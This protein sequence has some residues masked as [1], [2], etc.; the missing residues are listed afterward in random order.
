VEPTI[1][2]FIPDWLQGYLNTLAD[3]ERKDFLSKYE[4]VVHQTLGQLQSVPLNKYSD[5]TEE[6]HLL[7][8]LGKSNV[9]VNVKKSVWTTAKYAG[10]LILAVAVS[11]A[12]LAY[13]GITAAMMP[14]LTVGATASAIAALCGAFEKLSPSELDTYQ[15]VAA[16]IQRNRN[17]VLGNAGAD[18][19][20][21]RESFKLD[22][23]LFPPNDLESMLNQLV[24]KQV[25]KK[26]VATGV[27]QIFLAF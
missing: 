6:G 5:G 9:F 17:R 15:A 11:P 10:P 25:L 13:L 16:A 26:D 2:D 23:D 1:E 20:E 27:E 3:D 24:T 12:L 7:V 22:R 4:D 18:I 21:I 8:R 14:H 19:R